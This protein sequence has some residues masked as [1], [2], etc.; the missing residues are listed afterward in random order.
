MRFPLRSHTCCV[1]VLLCL[2]AYSPIHAA[3]AAPPAATPDQAV[4]G[5]SSS[6]P[7]VQT[8]IIPGPMRSFLRMAGV[9]QEVSTE[10]V[11]PTL[12]RNAALYGYQAGRETAILLL[13]SRYVHQGRELLAMG[14]GNGT[15]HSA[16][17]EEATRLIQVLG[18][19]FQKPCGEPDAAL[20]TANVEREFLT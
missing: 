2:A 18:Y 12:A 8:L 10:E 11:L 13:V 1:V 5:A 14:D 3:P 7:G 15:I 17:C 9:S 20:V 19:R 4:D 16:K 6:S